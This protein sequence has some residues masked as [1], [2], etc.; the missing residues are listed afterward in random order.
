LRLL[1]HVVADGVEGNHDQR[2]AARQVEV[3]HVGLVQARRKPQVRG[4]LPQRVQHRR[5]QVQSLDVDTRLQGR[6]QDPARTATDIQHRSPGFLCQAGVEVEAVRHVFEEE[7]V[8]LA[9]VKRSGKFF[10]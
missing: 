2:V 5:K 7:V 10:G 4:L 3:A 9:V 1:R 6:Q 8:D